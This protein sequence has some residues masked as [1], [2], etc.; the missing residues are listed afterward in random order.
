VYTDAKHAVMMAG[1]TTHSVIGEHIWEWL[2]NKCNAFVTS[3]LHGDQ[4]Y[5]ALGY[6]ASKLA[7]VLFRRL[8]KSR[9]KKTSEEIINDLKAAI[10]IEKNASAAKT[11]EGAVFPEEISRHSLRRFLLRVIMKNTVRLASALQFMTFRLDEGVA[12]KL[13]SVAFSGERAGAFLMGLSTTGAGGAVI[14]GA[15]EPNESD[16]SVVREK[17]SLRPLYD[18][19]YRATANPMFKTIG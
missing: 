5:K 6:D 7:F 2:T 19:L 9:S 13:A 4:L 8:E 18:S 1:A 10:S 16:V 3:E 17:G 15:A 11:V 12:Q 14:C